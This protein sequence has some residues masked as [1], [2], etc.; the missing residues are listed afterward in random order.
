M[1]SK[2]GWTAFHNM[3]TKGWPITTIVNGHVIYDNEELNLDIFGK[4]VE[5]I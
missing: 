2:C 4:E 3:K 5:F 1:H